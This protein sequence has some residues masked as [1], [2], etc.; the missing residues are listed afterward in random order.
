MKQLIIAVFT[1]VAFVFFQQ[2]S[3]QPGGDKIPATLKTRLVGKTRLK[4]IMKEVDA[5]YQAE[6]LLEAQKK[7]AGTHDSDEEEEEE[8]AYLHWKRWEWY[9]SGRLGPNGE[10]VDVKEQLWQAYETASKK[11]TAR[12]ITRMGLE[13]ATNISSGSW[14]F[15]GPYS[16]GTVWG[17]LP[18]NGRVD[19][20]AFDPINA[21]IIY[22]GTPNGGLWKST[23]GGTSWNPLPFMNSVGVS[24]IVIDKNNTNIIYVLTGDGDAHLAVDYGYL[25]KS[26]GILKSTDGGTTW[27]RIPLMTNNTYYGYQLAMHPTNS[28]ILM[29]ATNLALLRSSDAGAT[30]DIIEQGRF[31]DVKFNPLNG[32]TVIAAGPNIL[33]ISYNAGRNFKLPAES[34][35][36]YSGGEL[37]KLSISKADTNKMYAIGGPGTCWAGEG[38]GFAGI[39]R[40]V[41]GGKNWKIVREFPNILS[42]KDDG[43]GCT[44]QS[45]YDLALT[46]SPTNAD[47]LT[48]GAT[49]IW[50]AANGGV[51][52]IADT[53]KHLTQLAHYHGGPNEN[54]HP[55]VHALEYNPL[56]NW[57]YAGTD[58]GIY[59]SKNNGINWE[60]ISSGLNVS[61]FYHSTGFT[62]DR[63]HI[64]GG[65]QDN[66]IRNRTTFTSAFNHVAGGDGYAGAYDP[67]NSSRFSVVVNSSIH[68]FAADGATYEG[69]KEY[70]E[71]FP[72]I[73][74]H[75]TNTNIVWL[76][77]KDFLLKSTNEGVS[78]TGESTGANKRIVF[79]PS[80]PNRIYIATS[81]RMY[82]SD[83]GGT[84]WT[85]LTYNPGF[86]NAPITSFA[87]SPIDANYIFATFGM[88]GGV[89]VFYSGNGGMSWLN[90]GADLPGVPVNC[91]AIDH[92]YSAYIGTDDGIYYQSA[93]S[94]KWLPYYNNLPRVPVT[95]LTIFN[96]AT[97][98]YIY[99]S[100]Y[101]RGIWMSSLKQ[102]CDANITLSG[103]T[104][105]QQFFQAT[106][107]ISSTQ[108]I[109]GGDGTQV[110]YRG[111]GAVTIT[112]GFNAKKG[113]EW[114]AYIGP[115]DAHGVPIFTVA[116]S[117]TD[118]ANTKMVHPNF[119]LPY[120]STAQTNLPYGY[121]T[122]TP[123][124]MNTGQVELTIKKQGH[125][126]ISITDKAGVVVATP[127]TGDIKP[128]V[129]TRQIPKTGLPAGFYYIKLVYNGML[130]HFL[131]WPVQ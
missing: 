75:P 88:Y 124:A 29:A 70:V 15:V 52:D 30:W 74:R 61:M 108:T 82:R 22:A 99:A 21:G 54:V 41:N 1:C 127:W 20:I 42:N 131:E 40:S 119:Y 89:G 69:G 28:N 62:G 130:A 51:M 49:T 7:T 104:G 85:E 80:N 122:I 16:T 56:N 67:N 97:D 25:R 66:G 121:L 60:F 2:S 45:W 94:T 27:T 72:F 58:G 33:R 110:Q 91:V 71:F 26:I 103:P 111:G 129:T 90:V 115:C 12:A 109:S 17:G 9:M 35:G 3:A 96:T 77:F 95:D 68:R 128:G 6:K 105:G 84:V 4:E 14:S 76:G 46:V 50:S 98:K 114:K 37:V 92:D 55:D 53:M 18:G 116:K 13:T 64:L 79:C 120:D 31:T 38:P 5:F 107:T 32:S 10:F 34:Y 106:N 59:L 11:D 47:S 43:S 57:L 125:Y 36:V 73:A 19:R 112:P 65:L 23:N 118:T 81:D 102:V 117:T 83:D 63:T 126:S 93:S 78:F 87:V 86:P 113:N 44:D 24:G 39:Q 101:G 100:T 123:A 48:I 8:N